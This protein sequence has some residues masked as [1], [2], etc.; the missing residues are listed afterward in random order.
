MMITTALLAG[1]VASPFDKR[2]REVSGLTPAEALSRP[3]ARGA[4]VLWGGRVVGVVNAGEQTELEM[5]A[6]PLRMGDMPDRD[7]DGSVR[8]VIRH[9]G[10]L[11]PMNFAPGRFVTA[12]GRFV[13]VEE[14]SVGAFPLRH[15]VMES[16]QLELW[17]VDPNSNRPN[18]NFGVGVWF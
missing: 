2:G 13:D 16:M 18:I 1:C 8:F 11:E 5:L 12:M 17:P 14:R 15:A 9:N 7:A 6:L 3:E 10:F 4:L